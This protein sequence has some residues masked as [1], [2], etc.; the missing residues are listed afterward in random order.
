MILEY[1]SDGIT[2]EALMDEI[3]GLEADSPD[4]EDYSPDKW[5]GMKTKKF[6]STREKFK[7][8]EGLWHLSF[9]NGILYYIQFNIEFGSKSEISFNN[10]LDLCHTIFK[11]NNKKREMYNHLILT[12]QKKYTE[13]RSEIS[14]ARGIPDGWSI[15]VAHYSW[16]SNRKTADLKAELIWPECL[17]VEYTEGRV[18]Q[19]Q[20]PCSES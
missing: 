20:I 8:R 2:L 10:C 14:A 6:I 1:L 12:E 9:N 3:K 5:A 11:I 16:K 19:N 15:P 13:F 4:E 18:L 7:G 17:S